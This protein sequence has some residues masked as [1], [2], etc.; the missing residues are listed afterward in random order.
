M[1]EKNEADRPIE[2]RIRAHVRERMTRFGLGVTA[3]AKMVDCNQG[4][5]TRAL[6]GTRGFSAGLAYRISKAFDVDPAILFGH[7]PPAEFFRT[8]VPR[9]PFAAPPA[10]EPK[11]AYRGAKP[12]KK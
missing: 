5:L 2:D 1:G 11:A 8:Y 9:P 10:A 7:D 4:Y 12:K 3:A 6:Q